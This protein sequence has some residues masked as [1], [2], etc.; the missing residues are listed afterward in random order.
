MVQIYK[1]GFA[2]KKGEKGRKGGNNV[3]I[4]KK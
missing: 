2:E 1:K 4:K 3:E